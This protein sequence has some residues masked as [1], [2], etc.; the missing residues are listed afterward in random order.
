MDRIKGGSK[1][2]QKRINVLLS[3]VG[4]WVANLPHSL[5]P[6]ISMFIK[7]KL[8]HL[9]QLTYIIEEFHVRRD[10]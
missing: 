3:C 4:L 9:A 8:T 2:D 6:C 1:W 5:L 7:L 10:W